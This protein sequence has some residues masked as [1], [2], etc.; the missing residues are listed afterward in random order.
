MEELYLP[1]AKIFL[2]S[3]S[4]ISEPICEKLE[5]LTFEEEHSYCTEILL[6]NSYLIDTELWERACKKRQKEEDRIALEYNNSDSPDNSGDSEVE[7]ELDLKEL[8]AEDMMTE[9]G[10]PKNFGEKTGKRKKKQKKKKAPKSNCELTSEPEEYSYCSEQ[11]FENG[12]PILNSKEAVEDMTWESY[13]QMH[14]PDLIWTSWLA[15][16]PEHA[17]FNK[18]HEAEISNK[19]IEIKE[20][21]NLKAEAHELWTEESLKAWDEHVVSQTE[22]YYKQYEKWHSFLKTPVNDE[23]E[24]HDTSKVVEDKIEELDDVKESLSNEPKQNVFQNETDEDE[25][26]DKSKVVEDEIEELDDVKE[27]LSNESK[28][29]EKEYHTVTKKVFKNEA[30]QFDYQEKLNNSLLEKGFS[31]NENKKRTYNFQSCFVEDYNKPLKVPIPKKKRK[32]TIES[33]PKLHVFF[34]SD[35]DEDGNDNKITLNDSISENQTEVPKESISS[36]FSKENE[37]VPQEN[38]ALLEKKQKAVQKEESLNMDFSQKNPIGPGYNKY[39][40]QRYRLFS[41][42]DSGIKLD[43]ESWHSVTP[44]RIAQ[45]IAHRMACDV[46]ID[47]FCGAGGNTIQLAMTCNHVVAID[48]DPEK[49]EL[50]RNNA[51]VYGVEERIEFIIGDFLAL[52]PTMKADS[53][54]LSPPWGGPKYLQQDVYPLS[55]ISPPALDIFDAACQITENIA[56]F[57]PRNVDVDEVIRLAVPGASVEV[58]QN[59]L[60]R[61][62]KTVTAYYGN[63]ISD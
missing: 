57:L 53:V 51:R 9:M 40:S 46:V 1:L 24:V 50:A 29:N 54:F 56:F 19:D 39:W 34:D 35:S 20:V 38:N 36:S 31:M 16:H 4:L 13:W 23:D 17:K 32:R 59:F 62:V 60:N 5:K 11:S 15:D 3:P 6:S 37:I 10:L 26:H 49:I 22:Y 45:H 52:A 33:K 58:E 28:Q 63:L 30:A 7:Q 61:R 42:F 47:A 25:V 21:E 18:L 27:S 8:S 44:E 55:G 48:I 14:G 43:L 12:I 2:Y 41:L